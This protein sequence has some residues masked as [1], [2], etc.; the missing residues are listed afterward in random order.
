AAEAA[1]IR[2]IRV[3]LSVY[4]SRPGEAPLSADE[5]RQ[6]ADFTAT[7]ATDLPSVRD[8][9]V[10]NEPNLNRFWLPQFDDLGHDTAAPTYVALLA[11]AY[12]ALKAVSPRISVIGGALA[13]RGNDNPSAP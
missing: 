11:R 7:L 4:A 3:Y 13:P 5:Q 9:I 8:F 2:R 1:R 6:F 10:W 12:D